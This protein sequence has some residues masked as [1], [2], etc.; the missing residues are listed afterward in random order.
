MEIAGTTETIVGT[1]PVA[2][3]PT[4]LP[5]LASDVSEP[6]RFQIIVPINI[7]YEA[8]RQKVQ[9]LLAVRA[10]SGGPT[11]RDVLVYPSDGK[12]V[13]GLALASPDATSGDGDWI[14]LT[15][16]PRIDPQVQVVRLD[17]LTFA[18]DASEA[19]SSSFAA[20]FNDPSLLQALREQLR[21]GYQAELERIIASA[22]TRLSRNLGDGFRSEGR[23][24]S[25]GLSKVM[26]LSGSLRLDMRADGRLKILY[27][28]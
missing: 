15:A 26:L 13:V 24:T 19:E 2:P 27:G 6:G 1:E 7:G 17:D 11:L 12:I 3:T 16:T 8:I 5:S 14:Y 23:L 4:P 22:N 28:L 21:L 10:A 18:S 9:D 25:V 20:M